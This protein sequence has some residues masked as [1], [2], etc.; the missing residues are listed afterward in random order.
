[1][2][3]FLGGGQIG[4][5][6]QAGQWV[7]GLEAD[8][9]FADIKGHGSCGPQGFLNCTTKVDGLAT[10]AARLGFAVD[11]ALIYAKGGG[12]WAH[13]KLGVGNSGLVEAPCAGDPAHTCPIAGGSISNDRWGW[14]FGAG[15]EYALAGNWSA[16]VEYNY[17]DFGNKDYVVADAPVLAVGQ[18]IH[19]V[20][21]GVNYRFA[22]G[23]WGR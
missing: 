10:F 21:F 13:N 20:K 5:N 8:A 2:N 1:M 9:S 7:Y 6:W 22:G 4:Y 19:L 17:L 14:M 12:A 15:I 18:H 3:G 16:K 11:H 23:T